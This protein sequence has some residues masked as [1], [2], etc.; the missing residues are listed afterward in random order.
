MMRKMVFLQGQLFVVDKKD[1]KRIDCSASEVMKL[2]V[3]GG[4]TEIEK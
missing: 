1:V 4:V 2:V 3:S